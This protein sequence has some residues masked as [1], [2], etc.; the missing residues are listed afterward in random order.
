MDTAQRVLH[1]PDNSGSA[2]RSSS[3][4]RAGPS[5]PAALRPTQRKGDLGP[6]KQ[7]IAS[8][9][10]RPSNTSGPRSVMR[11]SPP[12]S[13][14]GP[15][16]TGDPSPFSTSSTVANS[17]RLERRDATAAGVGKGDLRYRERDIVA[18]LHNA[19]A[20]LESKDGNP[21]VAFKYLEVR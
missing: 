3:T 20:I 16:R 7:T 19:A 8:S 1:R 15:G 11:T 6:G 4:C 9:S 17:G 5:E 10:P 21:E 2:P 14:I 12:A 13:G 18:M